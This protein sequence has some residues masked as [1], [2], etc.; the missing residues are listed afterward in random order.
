MC[1]EN[2]T[3]RYGP[4]AKPVT[5]HCLRWLL[6]AVIVFCTVSQTHAVRRGSRAADRDTG[7]DRPVRDDLFWNSH[8]D[9]EIQLEDGARDG[10]ARSDRRRSTARRSARSSMVRDGYDDDARERRRDR[11]PNPGDERSAVP[12]YSDVNNQRTSKS[13]NTVSRGMRRRDR[14]SVRDGVVHVVRRGE[15]LTGIARKYRSTPDSIANANNIAADEPLRAGMRLAIPRGRTPA[16]A[17]DRDRGAGE[18]RTSMRFMWPLDSIVR[19]QR[20]QVEGVKSI[21]ILIFGRPGAPVVSSSCG[22]VEKVGSMRGFGKYVVI[23]HA[24]HYITVYSNLDAVRVRQG[25]RIPAG[26]EVGS[27]DARNNRLHFQ[28]NCDGRPCDPLAMLPRRG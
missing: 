8:D 15:H 9:S 18:T 23:R 14:G 2:S 17:R 1:P 13:A 22:V 19:V 25:E 21:G 4:V 12:R 16:P 28:I 24:G 11:R 5:A 6:C 7:S 20:E 26:R 10:S 3:R 27:I